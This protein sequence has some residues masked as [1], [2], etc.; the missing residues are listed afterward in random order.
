MN[1]GVAL[2]LLARWA[3]A[4]SIGLTIGLERGWHRRNAP[5]GSRIAGWRTFALVGLAGGAWSDLAGGNVVAIA[6]AAFAVTVIFSV[7]HWQETTI[8]GDRGTTTIVAALVTFTFG[9]LAG[10]GRLIE[11]AAGGVVVTLLLS[12]KTLLHAWLQKLT[13]REFQAVLRFLL[14]SVVILPLLPNRGMGPYLALNPYRLWTMVVLVAGLSFAGY[15]A[16]RIWGQRVGVMLTAVL[17]G[18]VSSTAIALDF[19]RRSLRYQLS[20]RILAAG[21]VA[22]TAVSFTRTM[23]LVGLL[24]TSL[25]PAVAVPVGAMILASLVAT[26]L[27]WWRAKE[28]QPIAVET[29][30]NPLELRSALQLAALLA[31]MLVLSQWLRPMLGTGGLAAITTLAGTFDIDAATISICSMAG[32]PERTA[33]IL[34]LLGLAGNSA[35]KV[36]IVGA[37]G[38]RRLL[39]AVVL[40]YAVIALA[41]AAALLSSPIQGPAAGFWPTTAGPAGAPRT[42]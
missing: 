21:I 39:A 7:A 24:K 15:A 5:E 27:L 22:A 14:I 35:L 25:L 26:S 10:Q 3:V 11:A 34:L 33:T 41:G 20:L 13:D 19:A 12:A 17:G 32:L 1:E 42:G 4:L 16:I 2:E 30:G 23:I 36:A 18:I 8:D 6:I 28:P 38:K 9:S 40:A 37:I 29:L 31:V